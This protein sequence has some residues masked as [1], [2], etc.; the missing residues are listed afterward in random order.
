MFKSFNSACFI[1]IH[2]A[3]SAKY[4]C[5]F[6]NFRHA[7]NIGS[8]EIGFFN[9]K[10]LRLTTCKSWV[11]FKPVLVIF[12]MTL[13]LFFKTQDENICSFYG[14][15]GICKFGPSCKFNHPDRPDF[16]LD[17]DSPYGGSAM[18]DEAGTIGS[19]HRSGSSIEQL[20]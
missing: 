5:S 3:Q 11:T 20:L 7:S 1:K 6:L 10:M 16:V 2:V 13:N 12:L 17:P 19:G 9:H 4:L 8:L 18:L 14:R 15:Y